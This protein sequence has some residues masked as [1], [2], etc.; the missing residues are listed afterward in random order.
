LQQQHPQT[1]VLQTKTSKK[2]SALILELKNKN[3][4]LSSQVQVYKFK[5][6]DMLKEKENLVIENSNLKDQLSQANSK[7]ENLHNTFSNIFY[8]YFLFYLFIYLF[9]YNS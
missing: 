4:D 1:V 7:I 3:K 9:Y 8:Y 2:E 5:T 6:I